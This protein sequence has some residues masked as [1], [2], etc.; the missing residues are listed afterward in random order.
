MLQ[1]VLPYTTMYLMFHYSY[2]IL[3][4]PLLIAIKVSIV[5]QSDY[6]YLAELENGQIAAQIGN[7]QTKFRN[8]FKCVG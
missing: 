8:T 3:N 2:S 7:S 4:T 5:L 6:I 1:M